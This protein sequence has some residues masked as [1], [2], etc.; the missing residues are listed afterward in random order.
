MRSFLKLKPL[1]NGKIT[2]SFTDISISC[3]FSLEFLMSQIC[4]LMLFATIKFS[5]KFLNLQYG[6]MPFSVA[7]HLDLHYLSKYSFRGFQY[8]NAIF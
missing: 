4:L 8:A 7:V 6:D 5:Q 2:M 3:P 1:R